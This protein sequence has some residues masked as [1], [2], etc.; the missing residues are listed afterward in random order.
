MLNLCRD[1]LRRLEAR[2]RA[3]RSTA[4]RELA[5]ETET[6][7]LPRPG[8]PGDSASRDEVRRIL[9]ECLT[10]LSPREREVFV[11]RDLSELPTDRVAE[12]LDI[13]ASSVRSL[14]TLARRRMREL[15]GPRLGEPAAEDSHG[16]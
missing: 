12:M 2:E 6:R 8:D 14:L 16:A 4:E 7:A 11:L 13:G 3:E 1:R 5:Q 15:L 9:V 10:Q